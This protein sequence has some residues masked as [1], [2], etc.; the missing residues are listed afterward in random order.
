ME[1]IPPSTSVK[2]P[3]KIKKILLVSLVNESFLSLVKGQH[4]GILPI[5]EFRPAS[6]SF[7]GFTSV[8]YLTDIETSTSSFKGQKYTNTG[9]VQ[10][11]RI[12]MV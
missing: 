6:L 9:I 5:E 8:F 4:H 1:G 10:V 3:R 11:V 7:S 12:A 2:T